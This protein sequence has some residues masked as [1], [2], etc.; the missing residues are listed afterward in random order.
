MCKMSGKSVDHLLLHCVIASALWNYIFN[1]FGLHWVMPRQ[2]VDLC[3]LERAI[4]SVKV[5]SVLSD[6]LYLER[7]KPRKDDGGVKSFLLQYPYQ[8]TTILDCLNF[9]SFRDFLNLFLLLE[10][11]FTCILLVYFRCAFALFNEFQ[12]PSFFLKI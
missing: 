4:F 10:K 7:E 2:M 8:W 3:P 12:L 1:L 6:V 9:S 5:G 11:C